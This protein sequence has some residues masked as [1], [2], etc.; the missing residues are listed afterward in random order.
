MEEKPTATVA[1][2]TTKYPIKEENIFEKTK[3]CVYVILGCFRHL[4][5]TGNTKYPD[6]AGGK[7]TIL[8]SPVPQP[9]RAEVAL[10]K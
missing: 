5:N 9:R 2:T 6:T 1:T 3:L 10:V 8:N 7:G 4:I